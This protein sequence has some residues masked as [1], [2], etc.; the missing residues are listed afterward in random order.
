MALILGYPV[1]AVR[2]MAIWPADTVTG[3]LR[4]YALLAPPAAEKMSRFD[5]TV[6]PLMAMLNTR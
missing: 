2:V 6:V 1:T 4:S 3:K 5:C